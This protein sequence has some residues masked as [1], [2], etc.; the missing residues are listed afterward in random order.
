M[1]SHMHISG[2]SDRSIIFVHEC[3]FKPAGPDYMDALNASLTAGIEIDCADSLDL[4]ASVNKYLA[5]YSDLSR[6]FLASQ[7]QFYDEKL[8]VSDLASALH[9]LKSIDRK[10]GFRVGRYDKLPGK[11]SIKEF[12]VSVL[13]PLL[14]AIGL[15]KRLVAGISKDLGEYW[16]KNSELSVATL[17][18][19]RTTIQEALDRDERI[20]LIAHGSGAIVAYDALWQLSHDPLYAEEYRDSKIDL[21]LTLGCPLGDA[22]VQRQLRGTHRKGRERYPTNVVAWHNVSAEDDYVSHDNTVAND[23][24]TMLKQRQISSIRDYRVYN[25][26]IR[27]GVSNPHSAIG[28]MIHPRVTRIVV[29]WLTQSFG[30]PIPKSIL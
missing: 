30:K 25:M 20:M 16:K 12:A 23:F 29:D 6:E 4:F 8:D 19:V 26:V 21:L 11:S 14:S 27:Y 10:K 22:T 7:R 9:Q 24:S 28:Y 18:R 1:K 5:Y 15:E 17:A 3:G 13:S 2:H